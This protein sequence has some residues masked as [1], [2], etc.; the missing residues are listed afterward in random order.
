MLQALPCTAP[1]LE[2]DP[3]PAA[4]A[5][6]EHVSSSGVHAAEAYRG[7]IG[8]RLQLCAE[9]GGAKRPRFYRSGSAVRWFR[10]KVK[11]GDE[12]RKVPAVI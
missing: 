6:S 12:H 1:T 4:D 9:R 10:S 11:V 5:C 3:A 2:A 7:T 8:S